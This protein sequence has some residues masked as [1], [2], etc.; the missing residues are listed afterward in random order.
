LSEA[1]ISRLVLRF[2][3]PFGVV[4]W[5][6]QMRSIC[7]AWQATEFPN[8]APGERPSAAPTV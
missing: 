2:W 1:R 8:S 6:A 3:D 7:G 4:V 5:N